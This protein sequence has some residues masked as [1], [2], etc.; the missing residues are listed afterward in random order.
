MSPTAFAL[1]WGLIVAVPV[2]ISYRRNPCRL[3]GKK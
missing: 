1:T 2:A 3:R